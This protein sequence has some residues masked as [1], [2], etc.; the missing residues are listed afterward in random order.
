MSLLTRV[1]LSSTN[2]AD[3]S[4]VLAPC[5]HGCLSALERVRFSEDGCQQSQ[6]ISE[7]DDF[8]AR[9]HVEELPPG[10]CLGQRAGLEL[11][12]DAVAMARNQI[13]APVAKP[14]GR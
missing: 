14:L 2:L 9:S 12:E 8:W 6:M 10:F 1:G 13:V 5:K 7:P 11:S 3:S 4:D